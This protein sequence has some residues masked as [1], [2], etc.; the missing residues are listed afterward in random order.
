SRGWLHVSRVTLCRSESEAGIY[1][2]VSK[3]GG[4]SFAPSRLVQANR[5]PEVLYK[6]LAFGADDTVYLAWSNLD[7]ENRAQ[8][9][10]PA[11]GADWRWSEIQQVSRARGDASRPVLALGPHRLH[12]AW[13]ETD[14]ETSR[15]L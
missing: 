10:F 2:S 13:T 14:G 15:A 11:I 3:A 6:S 9:F 4:T 7:A 12:V 5:A 1:C 8:I